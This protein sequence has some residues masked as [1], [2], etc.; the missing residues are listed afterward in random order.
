MLGHYFVNQ[1][2]R[3]SFL[4][5]V[6]P[7][8]SISKYIGISMFVFFALKIS[9]AMLESLWYISHFYCNVED[10]WWFF[11]HQTERIG[12]GR[13]LKIPQS[14]ASLDCKEKGLQQQSLQRVGKGSTVCFLWHLG[15]T[16]FVTWVIYLK[17]QQARDGDASE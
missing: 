11:R 4:K 3:E 8:S 1:L 12:I 6:Y 10:L 5:N 14:E 16:I 2:R 9:D 15:T 17:I 7:L 13:T